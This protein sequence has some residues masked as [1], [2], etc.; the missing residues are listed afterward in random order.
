M[1]NADK[2]KAHV[3]AHMKK[4]AHVD[5]RKERSATH[6]THHYTPHKSHFLPLRRTANVGPHAPPCH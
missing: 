1:S 6:R 2:M 4:F 5:E 3:D